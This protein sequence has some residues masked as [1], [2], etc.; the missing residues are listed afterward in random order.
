MTNEPER[1]AN[2]ELQAVIFDFGGVLMRTADPRPRWELERRLK[3][4]PGGTYEAV[5]GNPLWD[6]VQL[7][8]ASSEELWADI[9]QRLGLNVEEVAEFR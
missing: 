8:R 5:F 7:G 6:Q 3:L 2:T 4:A 1:K 9:G